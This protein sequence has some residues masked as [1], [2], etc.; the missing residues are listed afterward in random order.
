MII[1]A[2][3]TGTYTPSLGYKTGHV[4]KLRVEGNS[5]MRLDHTGWCPYQSLRAFLRN[6]TNI[7]GGDV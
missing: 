5:I 1:V 3:F 7:R 2:T 4:Y 6:W